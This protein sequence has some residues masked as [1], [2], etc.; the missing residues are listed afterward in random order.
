MFRLLIVEDD[1]KVAAFMEMG[2][3]EEAFEVVVA[4]D[5]E[6]GLRLAREGG[7]DLILLD[8]MLPLRSGLDILRAI[9]LAG[10]QVPVLMLSARGT[11]ADLA[12]ALAAGASDYVVKPFR[13]HELLQRVASAL[14]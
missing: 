11:D 14:G 3:A 8:R 7:F 5:G 2:L 13:F 6:T 4:R 12:E 1:P 10:D 9:R